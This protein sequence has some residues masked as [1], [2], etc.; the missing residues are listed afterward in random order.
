MTTLTDRARS[1]QRGQSLAEFALVLPIIMLMIFGIL[2]LGRAVYA[3]NTLSEAA[4][5]GARLAIVNQDAAAVK[6]EAVRVAPGSG[7]TPTSVHLCLMEP[8]QSD[9]SCASSAFT[10]APMRIG[11]LAVVRT[12]ADFTAITP[13]ISDI[14]GPITLSST[15]VAPIEHVLCPTP[16]V[17]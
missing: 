7:L 3:Y 12:D 8:T 4:R 17:P 15:S 16:C 13:L 14:I 5:Q 6:A 11:C 1:T 2:D 10:C 9:P